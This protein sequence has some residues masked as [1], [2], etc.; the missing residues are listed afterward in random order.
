VDEEQRFYLMTQRDGD[1]ESSP[2]AQQEVKCEVRGA[3]GGGCV[4]PT[5]ANANPPSMQSRK[6]KKNEKPALLR[7]FLLR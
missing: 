1:G 5:T 7:P 2:R 4:L 6:E 3:V